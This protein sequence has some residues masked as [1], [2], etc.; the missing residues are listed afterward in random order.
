MH[1][2][3]MKHMLWNLLQFCSVSGEMSQMCCACDLD[4]MIWIR[5]TCFYIIVIIIETFCFCLIIM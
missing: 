3:L 4:D 2:K 5:I 1:K